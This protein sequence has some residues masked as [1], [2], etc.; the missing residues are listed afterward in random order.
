MKT[1]K[2]QKGQK[3]LFFLEKRA[4]FFAGIAEGVEAQKEKAEAKKIRKILEKE[5]TDSFEEIK[6]LQNAIDNQYLSNEEQSAA[7]EILDST[8]ESSEEIISYPVGTLDVAEKAV[9]AA[10]PMAKVLELYQNHADILKRYFDHLQHIASYSEKSIK[11]PF[12]ES[13]KKE[14]NQSF[15][16]KNQEILRENHL[17]DRWADLMELVGM[18]SSAELVQDLKNKSA[19][20]QVVE[21]IKQDITDNPDLV[22]KYK[23]KL[24]DLEQQNI[25][26]EILKT[27]EASLA[28]ETAKEREKALSMVQ[29][30]IETEMERIAHLGAKAAREELARLF[31]DLENPEGSLLFAIIDVAYANCPEDMQDVKEDFK[32]RIRMLYGQLDILEQSGGDGKKAYQIFRDKGWVDEASSQ[33]VDKIL[34]AGENLQLRIEGTRERYQKVIQVL[35]EIYKEITTIDGK[36]FGESAFFRRYLDLEHL[37]NMPAFQSLFTELGVDPEKEEEIFRALKEGD[38][39]PRSDILLETTLLA[40]EIG[41]ET[42]QINDVVVRGKNVFDVLNIRNKKFLRTIFSEEDLKDARNNKFLQS[43]FDYI[44]KGKEN[45]MTENV[46]AQSRDLMSHAFDALGAPKDSEKLKTDLQQGVEDEIE[47][48]DEFEQALKERLNVLDEITTRGDLDPELKTALEAERA[49]VETMLADLPQTKDAERFQVSGQRAGAMINKSNPLDLND[50]SD[51]SDS[52]KER[53]SINAGAIAKIR[54]NNAELKAA[55]TNPNALREVVRRRPNLVAETAA[56]QGMQINSVQAPKLDE[57]TLRFLELKNLLIDLRSGKSI[58]KEELA[59]FRN[60]DNSE[61]FKVVPD[62]EWKHEYL[63]GQIIA[64]RGGG[65]EIYIKESEIASGALAHELTHAIDFF[66]N[67]KGNKRLLAKIR[68]YPEYAGWI[69]RFGQWKDNENRARKQQ[70]LKETDAVFERELFAHLMARDFHGEI[71]SIAYEVEQKLQSEGISPEEFLPTEE[72]LKAG[73]LDK[74]FHARGAEAA[75]GTSAEEDGID[76]KR[77]KKLEAQFATREK[78]IREGLEGIKVGN[79]DGK[80]EFVETIEAQLESLKTA[81]QNATSE[82]AA[83]KIM[84]DDFLGAIETKIKNAL[85]KNAETTDVETGYFANLWDKTVI[86]SPRDFLQVWQTFTDYTERRYNTKSKRRVGK[87]GNAMFNGIND[88]LAAEYDL[89]SQ[90][91]EKEEVSK[92]GEPLQNMDSWQVIDRIAQNGTNRDVLKA[93]IREL[94]KRGMLD[95]RNKIIQ[96]AFMRAGAPVKFYPSDNLNIQTL[97]QKFKKACGAFYDNDEFFSLDRDNNSNYDSRKSSYE[98]EANLINDYRQALSRML[99]EKRRD[100]DSA[101]V[102]PMRYEEF[103]D[104]AI[105]MGKMCTE[106]AVYYII[107]GVADGILTPERV[108]KMD[109]GYLNDMPIIN[110]FT[111]REPTLDMYQKWG[112]MF[113]PYEKNNP[114]KM[115]LEFRAW[116]SANLMTDSRVLERTVKSASQG[117]WDHDYAQLIAGI[118]DL[119]SAKTITASDHGTPKYV[120]TFHPNAINGMLMHMTEVANNSGELSREQLISWFSR[121][122]GY[123]SMTDGIWYGRIYKDENHHQLSESDKNKPNRI[124][125]YFKD[126]S[127]LTT[128]EMSQR[129][130]L[131]I[132]EAQPEFFDTLF[133]ISNDKGQEA[134]AGLE[135]LQRLLKGPLSKYMSGIDMPDSIVGM[136]EISE[137]LVKNILKDNPHVLQRVLQNASDIYRKDHGDKIT[138]FEWDR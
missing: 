58:S 84:G 5:K 74:F 106:D 113:R 31:G 11:F 85:P 68:N 47:S 30:Q 53:T 50:F 2:L 63:R 79:L 29:D 117:K 64:K 36:Q 122:A 76:S 92:Y 70:N 138:T 39:R 99:I 121:Q 46:L 10:M 28:A 98:T 17:L 42:S 57:K 40:K 25:D 109:N 83:D 88:S 41:L 62:P 127:S 82:E 104:Y 110:Y 131:I 8:Y 59:N 120:A 107:M 124:D 100:G 137:A 87:A 1:T 136:Y 96:D 81:L 90:G 55:Q 132:R 23:D 94:A 24:S 129:L 86:L 135:N 7:Q 108:L 20:I 43:V 34:E 130:R 6:L 38:F 80:N 123:I 112:E 12:I 61:L 21:D 116:L 45:N 118:G 65:Y 48:A 77:R 14:C 19:D 91:A 126:Q 66:A 115:P 105:K 27:L 103:I 93:C 111:S 37:R 128:K 114:G 72:D 69:E 101:K 133:S 134:K 75:E 125:G 97:K 16:I 44:G 67:E 73:L 78:T 13:L 15:L 102:D 35:Q 33:R 71:G 56:I 4:V 9:L 32:K 3:N 119:S 95:W 22:D 49:Q 51:F 26:P 18:E 52:F 89:L 60:P 54:D